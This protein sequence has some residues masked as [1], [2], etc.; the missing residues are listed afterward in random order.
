MPSV[1]QALLQVYA[2]NASQCIS[3]VPCLILFE[4]WWQ[5]PVVMGWLPDW[6]V[7]LQPRGVRGKKNKPPEM[8][9]LS[10]PQRLTQSSSVHTRLGCRRNKPKEKAMP[11]RSLMQ[12]SLTTH[13]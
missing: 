7:L 6:C 8:L 3:K 2:A 5:P 10:L 12:C 1:L 11:A 9:V 13:A 4:N